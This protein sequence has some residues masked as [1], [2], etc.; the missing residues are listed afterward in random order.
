MGGDPALQQQAGGR[1]PDEL[2]LNA[3]GAMPFRRPVLGSP[4][5]HSRRCNDPV[6]QGL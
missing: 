2:W 4:H 3:P 5:R 1:A 6:P